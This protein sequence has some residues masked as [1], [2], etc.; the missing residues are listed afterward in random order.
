[1]RAKRNRRVLGADQ[2]EPKVD[3]V[4]ARLAEI[5]TELTTIREEVSS[6]APVELFDPWLDN[7]ACDLDDLKTLV[8]AD[9]G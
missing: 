8:T 9:N 2:E 5:E 3:A 6:G 1:V 4:L 7:L